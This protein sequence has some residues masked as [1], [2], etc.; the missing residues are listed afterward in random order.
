MLDEQ[1]MQD[2]Y[3]SYENHVNPAVVRLFRFMGLGTPEWEASGSVV[4]DAGGKEYID[5]LGG[6]GVFN[7][8]HRHPEVVAAVKAQLD[9]M[10][11]SSKV[12]LSKPMAD[13]ATAL[14][15]IL[16]GNLQYCFFCNSG[17]EAVEGAIKLA[18]IHTGK[19][20]IIAMQNSFHGKTM[21]ALSATGRELFRKPFEPL[22]QGFTHVE[23][24]DVDAVR[25]AIQPD[26]AAVIV[27]PV[28]GEGGI[29][30]PPVGYLKALRAL[31]DETG[32]LLICDEVQTGMGRTGRMFASEHEDVTPD[33][34]ALAKALGGGVMPIGAFAARAACWEEYITSPF[35]H[36]STF[37]GNPTACAAALVTIQVLL[38]DNLPARAMDIGDR[39]LVRLK[40]LAAA[41]PELIREVRGKGLMIGM[42]FTRE[43]IGGF[44][45]SE[46]ITAGVLVAYTLNNPNVIRIE[47][48]LIISEEQLE[49]VIG[50]IAR[51]LDSA[52]E[53]VEDL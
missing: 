21:G 1:M 4:R 33:I 46:L 31:C 27:E 12:F 14:A 48:P 16:P 25:S 35:L 20:G 17:A 42:E 23:F 11:L 24:G 39:F 9:R 3:A 50:A 38:R 18:R 5:C 28:Q 15:G 8:G 7:L 10:P 30:V 47:P 51:A 41:H 6:Y 26:T 40:R 29:I 43:G 36:T 34:I 2:V 49:I 52:A 45:M 53:I 13:L 22:L 32:V 37:G 44:L 19:P